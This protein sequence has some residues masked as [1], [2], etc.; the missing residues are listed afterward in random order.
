MEILRRYAVRYVVVSPYERIYNDI[1]GF[2]K[3]EIMVRE[4]MLRPVYDAQGVQVYE[5]DSR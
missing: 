5:V 2:G 1:T 4:G 3:F